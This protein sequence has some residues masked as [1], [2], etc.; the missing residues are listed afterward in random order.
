VKVYVAPIAWRQLEAQHF[1]SILPL[2]NSANGRPLMIQPKIGDALI[3]RQRG[4]AAIRF[5]RTDYDV[6]VQIDSD[7]LFQAES[8]WEIC[9]QAMAHGYV[10]GFYLTRSETGGIPATRCLPGVTY[11]KT[12]TLRPV[13]WL[14]G[15]FTAVRRDVLEKVLEQPDV[16]LVHPGLTLEHW[17]AYTPFNIDEQ[18]DGRIL[19][20]E[21]WAFSER[22]RR[23][24]FTNYV[25]PS[26]WLGHIGTQVY[27]MDD[28][29]READ[30]RRVLEFRLDESNGFH[31]KV[32]FTKKPDAETKQ[33]AA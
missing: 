19:L 14:G 33:E 12:D 21:D 2:V 22:V 1:M 32:G 27:T 17:T 28:L 5:L 10:G 26:V 6:M 15:G 18:P 20:G 11:A 31:I 23:A 8:V 13:K 16:E 3:E 7:I 24:G 30:G 25:N 9:E 29:Q 4:I